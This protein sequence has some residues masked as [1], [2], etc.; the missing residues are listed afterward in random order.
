MNETQR[1]DI[2]VWGATGFTGRLVAEYLAAGGAPEGVRW[3]MAG[4]SRHRLEALRRELA[5]RSPVA[6]DVEILVADSGDR[7]SLDALVAQTRAVIAVV[8]PF[9]QYGSEL[10]AAC[11]EAGVDY[12]DITGE[13]HWMRWMI[14][15]YHDVARDTGARI[16]HACGFDALPS[17][18]GCLLVQEH[19]L[20]TTGSPCR[21]VTYYMRKAKGSW[22]GGTAATMLA[23]VE[24]ASQDR[25]VARLLA[26]PYALNP[27]SSPTGA[28]GP[29]QRSVRYDRD[30][31]CWTGPFV[32][33]AVNTRVVRRTNALL[34]QRYGA[35][36]RYRELTAF[37]GVAGLPRAVAATAGLMGMMA[38]FILPPGRALMRRF[39][40]PAPGEGPSRQERDAGFFNAGVLGLL[41]DGRT[42]QAS[43]A[44]QGDPGYKATATMVAQAGLCLALDDLPRRGGVLTP[45]ACMGSTLIKRLRQAGMT[46]SLQGKSM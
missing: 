4:R 37:R 19:A 35:D 1:Y 11:A 41:P 9:A 8:G 46:F 39:V 20:A 36:F 42:I 29:D 12:C 25:G 44:G 24:L 15:R 18:L 22:S 21:S 7:A 3:A 14:D 38:G 2:V 23:T 13:V 27:T 34:E 17:D 30:L 32:M 5:V 16:V 40:L 6:A 10:V 45:A 26:D 43:V 33:A 28:D 31:G